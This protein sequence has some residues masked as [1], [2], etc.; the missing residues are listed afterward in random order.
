MD[1]C[2]V[3]SVRARMASVG[4]C[5][6]LGGCGGAYLLFQLTGAPG[7][8]F[9]TFAVGF[10][11]GSAIGIPRSLMLGVEL[12]ATGLTVRNYFRTYVLPW[13][14]VDLVGWERLWLG[15]YPG[16]GFVVPA[17]ALRLRSG[18]SI[19]ARATWG[20]F[21]KS[22]ERLLA[23]LEQH[24]RDHGIAVEVTAEDLHFGWRGA[25]HTHWTVSELTR[26][27]K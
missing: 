9:S 17:L 1:R 23:A 16:G 24:A 8:S 5:V 13:N 15:G 19:V 4:T 11:I 18:R 3:A 27:F 25:K 26:G 12:D 14:D 10:V 21:A 22:R 20:M 6:G 2:A 7:T